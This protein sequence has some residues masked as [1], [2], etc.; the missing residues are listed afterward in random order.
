MMKKFQALSTV[1]Q[2]LER[3]IEIA[4]NDPQQVKELTDRLMEA[5]D[6]IPPEEERLWGDEDVCHYLGINNPHTLAKMRSCQRIPFTKVPGVGIR[7]NPASIKAW[8][9]NF[10]RKP[11]P[12]WRKKAL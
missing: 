4:N 11:N 6:R 10:E 5:V 7:Y 3:A 9:K 2:A 8:A 12:A 1:I